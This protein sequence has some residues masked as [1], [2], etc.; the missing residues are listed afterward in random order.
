MLK[1]RI[2]LAEIVLI[3]YKAIKYSEFEIGATVLSTETADDMLHEKFSALTIYK[4]RCLEKPEL[5][6]EL[7]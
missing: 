1:L 3:T 2:R 6:D 7:S 5:L 4:V